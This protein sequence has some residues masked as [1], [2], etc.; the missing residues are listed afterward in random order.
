MSSFDEWILYLML[1][2]E[3]WLKLK[4]IY[5]HMYYELLVY[6]VLLALFSLMLPLFRQCFF[7]LLLFFCFFLNFVKPKLFYQHLY[8][9]FRKQ[10]SRRPLL[11]MYVFNLVNFTK[12]CRFLATFLNTQKNVAKNLHN[13]VKSTKLK[14][15]IFSRVPLNCC[16]RK[17]SQRYW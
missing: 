10:Q 12:L 13:F 8:E 6:W 1:L 2:L 9:S 5:L 3:I 15:Y 14:T 11:N 4:F 16:F 17:L 7:L